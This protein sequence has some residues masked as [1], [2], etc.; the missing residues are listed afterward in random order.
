MG[1]PVLRE[2]GRLARLPARR[3][4]VRIG[5]RVVIE[6]V[7]GVRPEIVDRVRPVAIATIEI[8]RRVLR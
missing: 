1:R 7:L 6:V 5:A 3:V 4:L 2:V 8:G